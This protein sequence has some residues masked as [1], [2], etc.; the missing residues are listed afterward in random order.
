MPIRV[1]CGGC[2]AR[3]RVPEKL[4]GKRIPCKRCD[5]R[6]PVAG[7]P[8]ALRLSEPA[9]K[10][11]RKRKR[12]RRRPTVPIKHWIYGIGLIFIG[13]GFLPIIG[14]VPEEKRAV[15][16]P[17]FLGLAMLCWSGTLAFLVPASRPYTVRILGV[18]LLAFG[19]FGVVNMLSNSNRGAPFA[20]GFVATCVVG[21]ASMVWKG[22]AV[23]E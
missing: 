21:G 2:G 22:G 10:P 19:L 9:P 15:A 7:E 20:L 17:F 6:I 23:A 13:I 14:M 18:A 16:L 11:N 5:D 4:A 8:P 1:Q 3:Y 12:R